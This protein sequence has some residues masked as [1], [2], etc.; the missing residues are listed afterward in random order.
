MFFIFHL[1]YL[2]TISWT[3]FDDLIDWKIS[4]SATLSK[5]CLFYLIDYDLISYNGQKQVYKIE[6]GGLELLS[7]IMENKSK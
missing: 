6:Q 2:S 3:T 4:S 5:I 7:G 1:A